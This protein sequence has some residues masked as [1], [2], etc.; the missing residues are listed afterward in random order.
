MAVT[1]TLLCLDLFDGSDACHVVCVCVCG[2]CVLHFISSMLYCTVLCC[3]V[4]A[5]YHFQSPKFRLCDRMLI[6]I[7]TDMSIYPLNISEDFEGKKEDV[8]VVTATLIIK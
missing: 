1:N 6:I 3:T 2:V 5:F 4:A 7:S 8:V